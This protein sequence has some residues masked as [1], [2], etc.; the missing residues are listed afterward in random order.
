[1]KVLLITNSRRPFFETQVQAIKSQGIECDVLTVFG[2]HEAGDNGIQSRTPLDYLRF[3]GRLY[4]R[5]DD[6]YDIV[7]ANHGLTAPYAVLQNKA[8]S[9]VT[10]W[11]SDLMGR[12]KP[13]SNFW[14]KFADEIIVPSKIM[15]EVLSMD[16]HVIPFGVDTDLFRPINKEYARERVGWDVERNI[17]L[18]PYSKHRDVKNYDLA[19]QVVNCADVDIHL[20]SISDVPYEEMPLYMNASDVLLVTSKRESGP[21]VVKEA[22]A[23]DTPV[24]STDV[25]FSRT[26]LEPVPNSIVCTS[27]IE[28]VE[29]L[30]RVIGANNSFKE[31]NCSTWG[32][33]EMGENLNR[34]YCDLI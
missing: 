27:V 12:L 14:A 3:F 26:V 16:H 15:S 5:L 9:V 13:Y 32:I 19:Q 31:S 22:V 21:M 23:C 2:A 25:G 24:L 18:F 29:A 28:F 6:S 11:G 34:V 8:P 33:E 20:K 30:E 4:S 10:L 7:H 17:A 1:M